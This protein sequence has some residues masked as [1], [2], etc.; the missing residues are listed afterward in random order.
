MNQYKNMLHCFYVCLL[1][2]HPLWKKNP[3][4]FSSLL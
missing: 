4:F 3:R 2:S 1:D